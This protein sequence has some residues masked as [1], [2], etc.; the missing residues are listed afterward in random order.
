MKTDEFRIEAK[1]ENLPDVIAFATGTLTDR[2]PLRAR[3]HVELVTEEI[4][5]TVEAY[6][7][8]SPL[9]IKP[10]TQVLGTATSFHELLHPTISG[11]Y[12]YGECDIFQLSNNHFVIVDG[13]QEYSATILV[14]YLENIVG[15][16][17]TPIVDAWFFTHA[18]PDH[19]YCTWGIGRDEDLVNRIKVNGFY[20]TWPNDVGFRRE[21]D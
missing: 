13:A 8:P 9:Q 18:H 3:M 4:F 10:E 6:R 14:E 17:N 20:Y 5:V 2:C 19:I 7:A 1:V 11:S 15:A 21:S 12:K 16:G